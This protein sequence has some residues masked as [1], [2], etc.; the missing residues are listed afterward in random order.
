MPPDRGLINKKGPGIKGQKSRLT[1]AFTSNADGSEK[2][3]PFVIG[4]AH[5]PRAFGKKTG[6]QLGFYY[7]NNAK[8]WM[9]A[10]LYQE[11]LRKWDQQLD[12]QIP[13][14]KVLL[15]QDN[16]SGHIVPTGLKNIR[17]ENFEP[18]LTAHIQPLDQGIIRCF[19]A[20][21]RA[22]YIERAIS[23]YDEGV[24]P[25]EIYSIDQLHAMRLA[26]AAWR[27]VDTTT[28]RN[29][30]HKS[31]ILPNVNPTSD[32]IHP[33]VPI[34]AL[35]HDAITTQDPISRAEQQVNDALDMLVT[36]GALQRCNR[37]DIETLLNPGDEME[38]IDETTDD[39][40]FRAVMDLD[41]HNLT[42]SDDA[43]DPGPIKSSP[44]H[45][46]ALQA[47]RLITDY[48]DSINDPVARKLEGLLG[49]LSHQ[50]CM[51]RS[52]GMKETVVTDY[53][54]RL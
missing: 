13:P 39:D 31:G 17:V 26:D 20:H 45:A 19:K 43:D 49:S 6:S 47:I 34:S 41:A 54:H 10:D 50:I 11:W 23:R 22:K 5:K 7:R 42:G 1:Y 8:A 32:T 28:I 53:F 40:I 4:K 9:T 52:K 12:H 29:C 25:S 38:L 36:T 14:R 48:I 46:E 35:I 2:L 51:E 33:S 16:F 15:L 24:T 44:T 27:E 37:V 30:W 3:E 21:Y 18:N